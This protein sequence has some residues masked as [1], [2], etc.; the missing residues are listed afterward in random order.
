M[1]NVREPYKILVVDDDKTFLK[2]LSSALNS[3][4]DNFV[5]ETARSGKECLQKVKRFKPN[6]VLLDIGMTGM[7]GLVTLRFIKS[8]DASTLVYILSG[9]SVEYIQDG[10]GMVPADGS[11]T[12]TQFV[13]LLSSD[14]SFDL[15]LKTG[16]T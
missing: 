7:N 2:L 12:K 8:I 4:D 1:T 5:V 3:K 13:A 6:L 11:F 14:Q 16:R 10:V 9:L 15:I